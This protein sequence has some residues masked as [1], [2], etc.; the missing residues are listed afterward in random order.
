MEALLLTNA[1]A[2]GFA[3]PSTSPFVPQHGWTYTIEAVRSSAWPSCSYRFASYPSSCDSVD[4]YNAVGVNQEWTFS[5]VSDDG[6]FHLKSSCGKYLSYPSDC[7]LTG[8]DMWSEAG[9]NQEFRFVGSSSGNGFDYFIEAVGRT[10]AGCDKKWL[11]FPGSCGSGDN[12]IDL[13][14]GAGANQQ[15]RIFPE[16]SNKASNPSTAVVAN[17]ACA[18]PYAWYDG[19]KR[20][21]Q[22]TGGG[23]GLGFSGD[24]DDASSPDKVFFERQGDSLDPSEPLAAWVTADKNARWAPENTAAGDVNY[25]FFSNTAAGDGKHRIGWSASTDGVE[26]QA[27]GHYS[28][29]TMNL[30]NTAGGKSLLGGPC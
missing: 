20:A 2:V 27:Y 28:T 24:G 25:V 21:L 19:T 4:L 12:F 30:G 16:R 23:L 1:S 3:A 5:K 11:S 26:V 8:V 17:F 7:S 22:C 10:A 9:I 18:D 14:S 6:I 13:W 15:F 29:D